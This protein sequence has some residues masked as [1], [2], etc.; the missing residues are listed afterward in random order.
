LPAL[1][2]FP[3]EAAQPD[4]AATSQELTDSAVQTFE[5]TY[6]SS[7]P[8]WNAET[9]DKG[10]LTTDDV[11]DLLQDNSTDP[12]LWT[13]GSILYDKSYKGGQFNSSGLNVQGQP[14]SFSDPGL[15]GDIKNDLPAYQGFSDFMKRYQ[16]NFAKWDSLS[17]HKGYLTSKDVDTLMQDPNIKGDDAAAVAELKTFESDLR[18]KPSGGMHPPDIRFTPSG[19]S[20]G[21][22]AQT[23]QGQGGSVGGNYEMQRGA[24]QQAS[25]ELFPDGQPDWNKVTQGQN[26]DCV[27]ESS[28]ISQDH[29]DPKKLQQMIAD[30]HDGTY[31][32][33][34]DG[35]KPVTVQAPTDAE[36]AH[37]G[38][39]GS[40]GVWSAVLSKAYGTLNYQDGKFLDDNLTGREPFDGING[41]FPQQVMPYFTGHGTLTYDVPGLAQD[42]QL[43][44]DG[45]RNGL[46]SATSS[47]RMA[48][49]TTG[50]QPTT[51]DGLIGEHAYAVIGY[52]K[53]KDSIT[54]RNPWGRSLQGLPS[55][56]TQDPNHPGLLTMPL[57]RFA[58]NFQQV[59]VDD[60]SEAQPADLMMF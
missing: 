3:P 56:I 59:V 29:V 44:M 37:Y 12:A 6:S 21:G 54:L 42:G 5:S 36:L 19:Y 2:Q 35:T 11:Q 45:L 55:D 46:V 47:G 13:M 17:G 34:F 22:S 14:V 39:A 43:G 31:T 1:Q 50:D 33:H 4:D 57:T 16:A 26:G 60:P 9:G 30:N 38:N 7:F 18:D 23:F 10:Y 48:L 32:V 8:T 25:H 24:L 15:Q 28:A 51:K 58:Q 49:A 41:S 20:V 27:L 53:D 52:D 40:N